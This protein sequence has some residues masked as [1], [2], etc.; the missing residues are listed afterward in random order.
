MRAARG[1]RALLLAA[2]AKAAALLSA[3]GF[4]RVEVLG[5]GMVQWQSRRISNEVHH[6]KD[7]VH[8]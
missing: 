3:A 7:T 1:F 5:G 8:P 6:G 2:L 4:G